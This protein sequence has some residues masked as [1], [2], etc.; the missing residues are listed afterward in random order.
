MYITLIGNVKGMG[1]CYD[2]HV[3]R[4]ALPSDIFKKK[5]QSQENSKLKEKKSRFRQN[6]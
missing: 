5:P 4:L 2:H 3:V 6:M 1:D